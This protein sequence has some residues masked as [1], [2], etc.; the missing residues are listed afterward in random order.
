MK[1][2]RFIIGS[3]LI[4]IGLWGH[5]APEYFQKLKNAVSKDTVQ[6]VSEKPSDEIVL[7]SKKVSDLITD[8]Q[9]RL[10]LAIFNLQFADRL[11]TYF[12]QNITSQQLTDLYTASLKEYFKDSLV[13]KYD[14]LATEIKSLFESS[15][16][17]LDHILSKE[18][19]D[20]L[21]TDLIGLS[22]NLSN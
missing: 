13:G 7:K 22:W 15:I 5:R 20:S 2:Y 8:N 1:D 21:K 16:G 12:D 17:S 9:D 19:V 10:N 4:L 3:V 14:G 6:I 18:E 11:K